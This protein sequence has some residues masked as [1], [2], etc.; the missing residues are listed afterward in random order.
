[1]SSLPSGTIPVHEQRINLP[2]Q[3]RQCSH[4]DCSPDECRKNFQSINVLKVITELQTSAPGINEVPKQR[5]G[6]GH[7]DAYE[8]PLHRP[9]ANSKLPADKQLTMVQM[10]QLEKFKKG[11]APFV[12]KVPTMLPLFLWDLQTHPSADQYKQENTMEQRTKI[13]EEWVNWMTH[14]NC[15]IQQ[16]YS[17]NDGIPI[18][19]KPREYPEKIVAMASK[20]NKRSRAQITQELGYPTSD[21]TRAIPVHMM[22]SEEPEHKKP[23]KWYTPTGEVIETENDIPP[24]NDLVIEKDSQKYNLLP[25]QSDSANLS[26][27]NSV[28]STNGTNTCLHKSHRIL[29]KKISIVGKE[30]REVTKKYLTNIDTNTILLSQKMDRQFGLIIKEIQES[31]KRLDRDIIDLRLN[32]HNVNDNVDAIGNALA[33]PKLEHS[34]VSDKVTYLE[35]AKRLSA[36]QKKEQAERIQKEKDNLTK[37]TCIFFPKPER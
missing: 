30:Q 29:D 16:N 35:R 24:W 27:R 1:M 28:A 2:A 8:V 10:Q 34:D 31:E 19:L 4:P 25:L 5:P 23:H 36:Q 6:L 33:E 32:L 12:K 17:R 18:E 13:S 20:P 9:I 7:P 14:Q 21:R 37:Q 3:T 26:D 15:W 22:D 11:I